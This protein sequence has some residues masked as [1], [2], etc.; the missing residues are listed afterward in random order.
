M[1]ITVLTKCCT[2]KLEI[3]LDLQRRIESLVWQKMDHESSLLSITRDEFDGE[4]A[5]FYMMSCVMHLGGLH[6][7]TILHPFKISRMKLDLQSKR[8]R[9]ARKASLQSEKSESVTV[10]ASIKKQT[11]LIICSS[12]NRNRLLLSRQQ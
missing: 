8:R 7:K 10:I 4:L 11:H 3:H 2:R 1:S 5:S 12:R 6:T 9:N